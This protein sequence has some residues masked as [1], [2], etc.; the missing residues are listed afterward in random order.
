MPETTEAEPD[1]DKMIGRLEELPEVRVAVLFGSRA[2]GRQRPDSDL[3]LGVLLETGENPLL[4]RGRI[5]AALSDLGAIDVID[6]D[7]APA[8]LAHRA[9]RDGR[10]LL[11]RDRPRWVR[12]VR[13]TLSRVGDEA[14]FRSILAQGRRK[15]LA[16]GSFGRS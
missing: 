16:E 11:C 12:L 3:D 9:L 5:A 6:L 14:Y 4:A 15:R 2:R 8:L 7:E 10:V 1:L 13:R